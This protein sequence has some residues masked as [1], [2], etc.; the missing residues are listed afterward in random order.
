MEQIQIA[1]VGALLLIVPPL[2]LVIVAKLRNIKADLDAAFSKIRV[3]EQ[4]LG[5]KTTQDKKTGVQNVS[6]D[7]HRVGQAG[8]IPPVSLDSQGGKGG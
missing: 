3:H 5:I 4:E 1:L 6:R 2:T 8:S 7:P